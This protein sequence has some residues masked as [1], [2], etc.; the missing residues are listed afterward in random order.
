MQ[1]NSRQPEKLLRSGCWPM[2]PIVDAL[3]PKVVVDANESRSGIAA[4]HRAV[5]RHCSC[6]ITLLE[7][8]FA[9]AKFSDKIRP[10]LKRV[11]GKKSQR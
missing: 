4:Y 10:T 1:K 9:R 5:A 7:Q 3:L 8:Q 2:L 6:G 11:P